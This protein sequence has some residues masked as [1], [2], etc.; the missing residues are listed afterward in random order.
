MSLI[1][2]SLVSSLPSENLF[3]ATA[4]YQ[5]ISKGNADLNTQVDRLYNSML[6]WEQIMDLV[7]SERGVFKTQDLDGNGTVDDN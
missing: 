5:G 2:R 4:V 1:F 6:A 3:P 7:Y